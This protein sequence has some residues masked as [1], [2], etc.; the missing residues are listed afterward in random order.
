MASRVNCKIIL[1]SKEHQD[2]VIPGE[3]SNTNVRPLMFEDYE[4]AGTFQINHLVVEKCSAKKCTRSQEK[5]TDVLKI[6]KGGQS[7]VKTTEG[8]CNFHTHP[9]PCYN[10]EK[11]LW[12]WPSGEDMRECVR[13]VLKGNLF[14]S[15]YALEG[16]Y[17][18][19]V[20]PNFIYL[21]GNDDILGDLISGLNAIQ[22]RGIICSL[23]ESYF[24]CTHGHR[25]IQ[26]SKMHGNSKKTVIQK[27]GHYHSK[28][29]GVCMP[30]DWIDFSNNFK[31]CNMVVKKKNSCST[32]LPCNGFPEFDQDFNGVLNL[33]EFIENFGFDSYGMHSN[34]KIT[35]TK[36]L[37]KYITP[38]NIKKIVSLFEDWPTDLRYGD[39]EWSPGQWFR[40]QLFPNSY[41]LNRQPLILN[42]LIQKHGAINMHSVWKNFD[43]SKNNKAN[44]GND[45]IFPDVIIKFKPYG[46]EKTCS[47]IHGTAI[48][49][50]VTEYYNSINN[51]INT[52]QIK[53]PKYG[54]RKKI[55]KPNRKRTKKT[56][57]RK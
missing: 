46:A 2:W 31:L 17:T 7:S 20:N 57:S 49:E 14:H 16:I 56:S 44:E 43:H 47:I 4:C 45:I 51:G 9:F 39:E 33:S 27:N 55:S 34:S 48:I 21:M 35:D 5:S 24:K 3:L 15:I 1:D 52:I 22:V 36:D 29:T 19:Q 28:D 23:I 11:T 30:K 10:G 18:V 25:T 6:N 12:G 42:N 54:S 13:F 53:T 32:M 40:C 37:S 8:Y 38:T 26:Y 41:V 50:W